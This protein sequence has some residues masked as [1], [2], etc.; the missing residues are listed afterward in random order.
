MTSKLRVNDLEN[1]LCK[2]RLVLLEYI[3]ERGF[4]RNK[5]K[6]KILKE[7]CYNFLSGYQMS[8]FQNLHIIRSD[9]QKHIRNKKNEKRNEY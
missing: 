3:D 4:G 2:K 9:V 1:R 6:R 7:N 5:K 8:L